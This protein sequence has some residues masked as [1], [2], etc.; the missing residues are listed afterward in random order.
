M[1]E[2]GGGAERD[3]ALRLYQA[4]PRPL[5]SSHQSFW[6][7]GSHNPN[8]EPAQEAES[9][10][11]NCH[12]RSLSRTVNLHRERAEEGADVNGK[13]FLREGEKLP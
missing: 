7:L 8:T 6:G 13:S 3:P 4:P 9:A 2:F 1:P 11:Q 10:D 12:R 5:L